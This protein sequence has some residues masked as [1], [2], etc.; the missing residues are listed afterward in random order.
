MTELNNLTP[1][2]KDLWFLPLGGCGEIGMNLN[3]YG[4][5]GQ[6]LMVD[7]GVTFAKA[8][9]MDGDGPKTDEAICADPEFIA[10]RRDRLA[11]LV[12]T[13][14]HEDHI[15][16]V[17]G[18]WPRL[19]CPVYTTPFT[20]EILRR[21]LGQNGLLNRVPIVVVEPG[22][23]LRIGVFDVEW[24]AL[25][26]SIPE[27][28]ALLIKTASGQVFHTADWKLDPDPVL[29]SRYDESRYR[30]LA[31]QNVTAMVCDSTNA[32]VAGRSTSEAAVYAGLRQLI[33]EANGRVVVCC[34]GS[35][36]ARLQTLARIAAESGRHM[37]LL[38]RSLHNMVAAARATGYWPLENK[39]IEP[40]HI[41]YLPANELLAVATGSQGEPRT[42]LSRLAGGYHGDLDLEPGDRVIF[43]SRTIPGNEVAVQKVTER[44]ISRGIEVI[45]AESYE[46][47]IHASG[48]PCADEL[49]DLYRWVQPAIAIPVHGEAHHMQANAVIA[50]DNLVPRQLTGLNGDLFILAP[51]IG[52]RKQAVGTG[53]LVLNR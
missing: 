12:I 36:V 21:K 46:G 30:R 28:Q 1:T 39:L 6:W 9:Q 22:S 23:Q 29:G 48:H 2:A 27:P 14:A 17:S 15:G 45:T 20:A 7:C 33:T 52:V 24:I 49:A 26:H 13:H 19:Q 47:V 35:N 51:R 40:A 32:T 42:A 4:H 31:R 43:S 8:N 5:D 10:R 50:R 38:G 11:G 53:Q 16:A 41:G 37:G 44:L 25:T 3:L 34:F 18:L